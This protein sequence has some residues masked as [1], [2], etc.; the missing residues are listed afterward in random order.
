[1]YLLALLACNTLGREMTRGSTILCGLGSGQADISPSESTGVLALIPSEFGP[2]P[3]FNKIHQSMMYVPS[4]GQA[5]AL[6]NLLNLNLGK[7]VTISYNVRRQLIIF[8]H[9]KKASAHKWNADSPVFQSCDHY[10]QGRSAHLSKVLLEHNSR[11][12][13]GWMRRRWCVCVQ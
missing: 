7:F 13:G 8:P 3:S 2:L 11:R 10:C 12:P 1:M 6:H 5:Q 4:R 9:I